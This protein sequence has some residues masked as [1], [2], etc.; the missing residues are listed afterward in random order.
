MLDD[1]EVMK[2]EENSDQEYGVSQN[3]RVIISKTECISKEE[4]V[5]KG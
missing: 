5:M 4:G 1:E 3:V 2:S